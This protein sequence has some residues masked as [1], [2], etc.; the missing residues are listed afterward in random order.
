MTTLG[1]QSFATAF[2]NIYQAVAAGQTPAAQPFF[3][4]AM[5]GATSAYCAGFTNCTAAIASKQAGNIRSTL[6]YNL[7]NSLTSQTSWTLGRTLPS[8]NPPGGCVISATSVCNQLSSVFMQTSTGYGNYNAAFFTFETRDWHGVSTRSNLTFGKALGTGAVTQSTSSFSVLDPWDLGAMYGPQGYD[9][10]WIYNMSVLYEPTYF[11]GKKGVLGQVLNGWAFAPLFQARTGF[12]VQ[13]GINTGIN[14]NC[15]SFGEMNCAAGNTNENAVLIAPYT[16]GSSAHKN[17]TLSGNIGLNTNAARGGTGINMFDNPD[18]V[19]AQFR[20][21]ILGL[22]HS[23]GGAGAIYNLPQWNLDLSVAKEFKFTERVGM[24]FL[25]QFA[26]VFNHF[27]P[28]TPS[29]NIDTPQSFG[30]ITSAAANT[31]PRQIEF[32][33][34]VHF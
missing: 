6:V 12:P 20:R 29:L 23:G 13:V 21:L 16:G 18:E 25:A 3:E 33:L 22:D 32:G 15:Q 27:Q 9:A 19:Y 7:W 24:T 31:N 14:A 4:A 5:G 17:L 26:N 8:S 2:A 30:H 28:G 1:G 34:R 10:R 11:K